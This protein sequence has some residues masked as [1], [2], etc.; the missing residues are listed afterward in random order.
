M[1]LTEVLNWLVRQAADLENN[2]VAVERIKEYT[3]VKNEADWTTSTPPSP[4]WPQNGSIQFKQYCMRY[5]DGLEL[6][7]KSINVSIKGGEKIGIVGRTGSGKSSLTVALFRLVEPAYG[8]IWIDGVDISQIGLHDLRTNLT[9]IPQDPVLF[10]GT[11]RINLDPFQKHSD[12]ELWA[13]L[14]L[15]H[16]QEFVSS[17]QAGLLSEVTEGGENLSIGQRQLICL[18]RYVMYLST[19]EAFTSC[20]MLIL[21]HY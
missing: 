6:V 5:R 11:L 10:S 4:S 9:I 1:T 18:A 3:E 8:S 15:A 21:G 7:L 17:L 13:A 20:K 12:A 16:L 19:S 14:E 2:I